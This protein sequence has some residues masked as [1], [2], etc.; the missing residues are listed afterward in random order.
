MP[1]A[2]TQ[3]KMQGSKAFA[4]QRRPLIALVLAVCPTLVCAELIAERITTE[5]AARHIQK[6]PDAA[7]GVGDWALGNGTLCAVVSDIDHESDL[8]ASGGALIDLGFCNRADDQFVVTQDLLDGSPARP[9]D[10]QRI[11]ARIGPDRAAIVSTGGYGGLSEETQISVSKDHPTALHIRKRIVRQH[12]DA[13]SFRLLAPIFF[14]YYSMETFL[15]SSTHPDRSSGFEQIGFS[16]Q[17]L[18]AFADA[19]RPVDTIVALGA[20]DSDVPVAYGWQLRSARKTTGDGKTVELPVF[21]ASDAGASAFLILSDPF[22]LGDHAKLGLA[23]MLQIALMSLEVGETLEVEETLYIGRRDDVASITDQLY[24]SAAVQSG[25]VNNPGAVVHVDRKSAAQSWVPFSFVRPNKGGQYQ[26]RLPPGD[27]RLTAQAAAGAQTSATVSVTDQNGTIDPLTLPDAATLE[28]PR[29]VAMRLVFQGL[30]DTPNPN[31]QDVLT[32]YSVSVDGSEVY[33]PAVPMVFLAGIES[34]RR[35]VELPAGEYRVLATRGI[36]YNLTQAEVRLQAGERL[37]LDIEE[38]SHVVPTPGYIATDLHVHS[39]PSMDNGFSTRERV[40]TFVAEHGEV[41]VATEHETLFDFQPLIESMGVANRIVS[42]TGTEMTGQV[43]TTRMPHT[44]GHANFF[45]LKPDPLA[46]RRGVPANEDRRL[47]EIIYDVKR[48]APNVLAQLNHARTGSAILAVIDK[49]PGELIDDGAYFDHMGP[50]AFPFNP[51]MPLTSPPNRTLIEPDPIT[52]VRDLDFD[53]LE[54]LNG[55][56][57]Y[58]P[59]RR[60]VL[61]ADWFALL[62]QGERITGTANSDSHGKNQQ[63]ALPRTMVAVPNDQLSA[64]DQAKFI[65][66]IR[67]GRCYG[68][69]GPLL[70]LDLSGTLMGETY[71][72]KQGTLSGQARSAEWIPVAQLRVRVNGEVVHSQAIDAGERFELPLVFQ[73]DSFVMIEVEAEPS[74]LYQTVYPGQRPYAFSNPIYVDADANGRWQ[75]PG[76]SR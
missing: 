50:A 37:R 5:N 40:R 7:G 41:M 6:G 31:L 43:R 74:T 70:E 60:K 71:Q 26:L 44:V 55:S 33:P 57:A 48:D 13:P 59:T 32:G 51:A 56:H 12:E 46:F 22:L 64:F 45:P 4:G 14:N 16:D 73:A 15:L 63:V 75:P 1:P 9:I 76:L 34:D 66:A 18:P 21:A 19:A 53:A 8:S 69:T 49:D 11:Q 42:V 27:Y 38:P 29:G 17:G 36:E 24:P 54:I 61:L 67:G 23:H 72:G 2:R 52:G 30:N 20:T 28:L 39:G 10:M 62:L 68:T 25:S 35:E 3:F 65:E 58:A 47:R